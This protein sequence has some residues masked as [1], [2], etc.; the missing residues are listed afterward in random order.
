V[1]LGVRV[2]VALAIAIMVGGCDLLTPPFALRTA[3]APAQACMDALIGGTLVR[4]AASG[5]GIASDDGPVTTVEWPFGYTARDEAGR[6]ALL[7]EG[8][9]VV[10]HVGDEI[11]VGGG[12]GT[13]VWYACG[14]VSVVTE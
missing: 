6:I 4:H 12:F 2:A 10:A 14:P 8:G 5:L 9:R 7:D 1:S 3:P 13:D 11:L